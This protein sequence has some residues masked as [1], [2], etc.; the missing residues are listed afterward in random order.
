MFSVPLSRSG[1]S[2]SQSSWCWRSRRRPRNCVSKE[3]LAKRLVP[4]FK[5]YCSYKSQTSSSCGPVF[6]VPFLHERIKSPI[7]VYYRL[8]HWLSLVCNDNGKYAETDARPA[9]KFPL[10]VWRINMDFE[11]VPGP[12]R[13]YPEEAEREESYDDFCKEIP[14]RWVF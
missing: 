2:W 6:K 10:L 4:V 5:G 12:N 13:S 7:Y 1:K 11:Y 9:A 3:S 8:S 14:E